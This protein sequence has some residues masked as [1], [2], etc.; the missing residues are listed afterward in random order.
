MLETYNFPADD[1]PVVA[2]S[3]RMALEE[4][5]PSDLG[6]GSVMEL[7][8]TVDDYIKQPARKIDAPFLLAVESVLVVKGRGTVVT[9][10]VE[11]GKV[12]INDD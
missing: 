6:T 2:G 3:A 10:K 9:G 1:T 11:Q 12:V 7:M 8:Q 4:E 5:E